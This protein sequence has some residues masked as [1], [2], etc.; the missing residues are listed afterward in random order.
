MKKTGIK[1]KNKNQVKKRQQK[2]ETNTKTRTKIKKKKRNVQPDSKIGLK[3][4]SLIFLN[5]SHG[6]FVSQ[7][8]SDSFVVKVDENGICCD[9]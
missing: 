5:F 4:K 2:N 7:N 3:T 1:I 9:L 8:L 6:D